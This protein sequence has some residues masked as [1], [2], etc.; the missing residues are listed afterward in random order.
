MITL[1]GLW[2]P[3]ERHGVGGGVL[4]ESKLVGGHEA[5]YCTSGF[6][7]WE[8]WRKDMGLWPH[9]GRDWNGYPQDLGA[10]IV[11]EAPFRVVANR[12]DPC[13]GWIAEVE[14]V[15]GMQ[16]FECVHLQESSLLPLDERKWWPAGTLLGH[17]GNTGRCTTGPHLHS[18]YRVF[19]AFT[20]QWLL[21]D[22]VELFKE[23]PPLS[24][25]EKNRKAVLEADVLLRFL[26]ELNPQEHTSDQ[27]R[28]IVEQE[29]KQL[30]DVLVGG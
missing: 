15:G 16:R 12:W 23:K 19:D 1:P 25:E 11:I 8:Q 24:A 2:V 22:P 28:R 4:T 21:R 20:G 7:V 26:R 17:L 6:L 14:F 13:G 18:N 9:P 5:I 10:P 29:V 30:R 3:D 27:Y